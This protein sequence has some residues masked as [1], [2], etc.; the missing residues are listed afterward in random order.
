MPVAESILREFPDLN[1]D[2]L[3]VIGNTEGPLLIIAGPGSGKTLV[4]VVRA[5]DNPLDRHRRRAEL[6]QQDH[7]RTD[8]P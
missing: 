2:Q 3:Q 7:R 5:L 4:L 8:R 1:D 6:L